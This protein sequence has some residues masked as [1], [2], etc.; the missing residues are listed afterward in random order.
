MQQN[1]DSI[2]ISEIEN[3]MEDENSKKGGIEDF[4]NFEEGFCLRFR[5]L[6][7]NRSI[8]I[9]CFNTEDQK[10]KV[11]TFVR[12]LKIEEQHKNGIYLFE[13]KSHI[14]TKESISSLF[15]KKNKDVIEVSEKPTDGYWILLQNWSQCSLK[16]GGGISTLHRMCIPHKKGGKPCQ[17]K[18]I[19]TKDCNTHP[20]PNIYGTS[21]KIENSKNTEVMRPIIK[22]MPFTNVPQRFT[23]C[24]IKESDMMIN[25]STDDPNLLSSNLLNNRNIEPE[26]KDINIPSRVVMNNST[27]SVF[28]GEHYETL[29]QT[30]ILKN[31][32][33]YVNKLKKG[34]FVIK[35]S[36]KGITLCPFGCDR[37][38]KEQKEWERDFDI[39]KNHCSRSSNH[40][41]EEDEELKKK[42]QEEMVNKKNFFIIFFLLI[43]SS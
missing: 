24:K 8:Y 35:E 6:D 27:L 13:E 22:I 5:T 3:I 4:G 36:K 23:L 30:F 1:I 21:E 25:F 12:S 33:Y 15:G 43:E 41:V 28:T 40:K 10:S 18:A 7:Q 19:L 2:S 14:Q 9:L 17:G 38:D 39:F 16:C 37:D 34:C 20:C 32:I 31:S 26:M 29:F 11:K 42:I